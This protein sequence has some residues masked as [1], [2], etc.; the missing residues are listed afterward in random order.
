MEFLEDL[1]LDYGYDCNQKGDHNIDHPYTQKD[2]TS[3]IGISRPALNIFMNELKKAYVIDF[4]SKQ[5]R[6][7]KTTA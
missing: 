6:I 5:I 4:N 2:I 7:S 1:C 3:L